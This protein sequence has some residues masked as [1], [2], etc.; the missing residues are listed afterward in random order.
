MMQITLCL[1]KYPMA[2]IITITRSIPRYDGHLRCIQLESR[3]RFDFTCKRSASY[4][5]C[6]YDLIMLLHRYDKPSRNFSVNATSESKS[7]QK[8]ALSSSSAS[9]AD[10]IGPRRSMSDATIIICEIRYEACDY[11]A[12][13]AKLILN[14]GSSLSELF[15]I[16]PDQNTC[17]PRH[18][19]NI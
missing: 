19:K 4:R 12:R 13:A 9:T 16:A 18:A 6:G 14:S 10:L 5:L 3:S 7:R 15:T 1:S 11:N 2:I 8:G 17:F